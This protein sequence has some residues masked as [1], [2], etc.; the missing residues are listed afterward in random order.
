MRLPAAFFLV[1]LLSCPAWA[2]FKGPGA[3]AAPVA[4]AL[5]AHKAP[6]GVT[7][8]LEDTLPVRFKKTDTRLRITVVHYWSHV[9]GSVEIMPENL[10]RITG[11]VRGKKDPDRIDPH[12]GVRYLEVL[13]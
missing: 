6:E 1:I 9:F 3:D 8:V 4:T 11:E 10:V 13:Q 12:L 2:A 7:C 5:E